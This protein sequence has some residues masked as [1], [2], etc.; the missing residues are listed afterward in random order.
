MYGFSAYSLAKKLS[1]LLAF[2]RGQRAIFESWETGTHGDLGVYTELAMK[3]WDGTFS[4]KN[5][6]TIE[7]INCVLIQ[8]AARQ[9][10]S[11]EKIRRERDSGCQVDT[12]LRDIFVRLESWEAKWL[13]RLLQRNHCTVELNERFVM[14]H[15]HFLLP[16]LLAFQNDFEAA[17][18]A[19]RGVLS[20]YPAIPKPWEEQS[21]RVEAVKKLK[22]KVGVKIGRPPFYKA[23]SFQNCLHLVGNSAWAAEVKYDGEYCEIHVNVDPENGNSNIRIFSKNGK[24]ATADRESL[25][26]TIRNAL[27]IGQPDTLVRKNCIVL[28]EMVVYNDDDKK[29]MDFSK[30]RNHVKRSGFF[31]GTLRDFP[32]DKCEHLMIVFF[33]VL[34][35]DDEPILRHSLQDRRRIL[36]KLIHVIPG[37]SMRSEW[38][39]LDFKTGN[40][41]RDLKETFARTIAE[42]QEGLVLKPLHAPYLPLP[43]QDQPGFLVKV[44]KDYLGDMGGERDLGDFAVVGARFDPQVA[45]KTNLKPL[46]WTHFYLGCCTNRD[47]ALRA[48]VK[49]RFKVVATLSLDTSISRSDARY[50]NVQG[51]FRQVKLH[52]D[53]STV[54]FDVTNFRDHDRRM[55]VAFKNPL[56]VEIL[57]GGFD[58]PQNATFEM[59]RHPR[60][61]KIHLDRTWE[62][63]VTMQDLERMAEEKFA[64]PNAKELDGH[65]KDIALLVKKY[66]D[67]S[68]VTIMSDNTARETIEHTSPPCS[69]ETPH[70]PLVKETSHVTPSSLGDKEVPPDIDI[71]LS[72]SEDSADEN[73][74]GKGL[75]ASR[76]SRSPPHKF[77]LQSS[78][79]QTTTSTAPETVSSILPIPDTQ[80]IV[81]KKRRRSRAV[82]PI[83][84]PPIKRRKT[85]DPLKVSD[86]NRQPSHC[87]CDSQKKKVGSDTENHL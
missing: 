76:E 78:T 1:R 17:F 65:A 74:Q 54:G 22:P 18:D 80:S 28:G 49:P 31:M 83:S 52:P 51:Y 25:R 11:D 44:K 16:D 47:A 55:T 82:E 50:L 5:Y 20:C 19:L 6:I 41:L 3:P 46:H 4:S 87:D 77:T 8:L 42:R 67:G 70:R 7:R 43:D 75:W 30:I 34:L 48:G 36:R 59:L 38:T 33:D 68:Q 40:G 60:V 79:A 2:N 61:Q 57:G 32:P 84:P 27:H 35:L 23:W 45:A 56:I 14:Q 69:P 10:F 63:A 71:D 24:D 9:R 62:D 66:L 58:T 13:V 15:Y 53:G 85:R 72:S 86:G 21:M 29:I 26:N 12:E 64:V 73:I 81:S 37:R 39:L